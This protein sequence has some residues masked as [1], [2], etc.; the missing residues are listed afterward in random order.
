MENMNSIPQGLHSPRS[1]MGSK[2]EDM[3]ISPK[4]NNIAVSEP[5]FEPVS[6][7]YANAIRS[8]AISQINLG[9]KPGYYSPDIIYSRFRR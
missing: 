4:Q 9:S 2:P 3:T 5:Q 6:K 8:L 7:E 1:I